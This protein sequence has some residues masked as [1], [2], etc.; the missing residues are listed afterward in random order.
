MDF[1]ERAGEWAGRSCTVCDGEVMAGDQA[2]IESDESGVRLAHFWCFAAIEKARA[3]AFREAAAYADFAAA[4]VMARVFLRKAEEIERRVTGPMVTALKRVT[5]TPGPWE[6]HVDD[7]AIWV[8]PPN[9]NE[10][11]ICE[12]QPRD[13]DA[14]TDEDEANARLISAAPDLLSACK[15]ALGAFERN[16]NIDWGELEA[17]IAKAERPA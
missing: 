10:A 7:S 2:G 14:F 8:D 9:A 16:D 6:A 1:L 15:L 13:A 5:H 12:L 11:V 17:A 3:E 4:P